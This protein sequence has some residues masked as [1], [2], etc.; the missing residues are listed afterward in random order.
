MSDTLQD[1]V[2]TAK[3]HHREGRLHLAEKFYREALAAAPAH[4]EALHGLGMLCLETRR[5]EEAV[6]HLRLAAAEDGSAAI[7]NNLGVALTRLQRFAEAAEVFRQAVAAE[8]DSVQSLGNLG[9]VLVLQ[10]RNDEALAILEKAAALA[11]DRAEVNAPLGS[12][13]LA[14]HR[15]AEAVPYLEKAVAHEPRRHEI[16]ADLGSAL[17][18]CG[19]F[20]EAAAAFNAVLALNPASVQALCGLGE[21]L[22][23]LDRHEDAA[24]HFARALALAPGIALLHYNYG[25]ALAF[26]GR[27]EEAR[28]AFAR[29]AALDP[30]VPSY[31]YAA[32][33]TKKTAPDD[34]HL[35]A[36][37][38]MVVHAERY[39]A[40]EQAELHMALA[41]AYDDLEAYS[42]AFEHLKQGNAIK[43]SLVAYDEEKELA[44][45]KAV[46]AVFGKEFLAARAGQG[47]PS[48]LP[49]FIVGMPRSG[50][51]LVEQILASHPA[52]YGAGERT[53]LPDLVGAGE[54]GADFP[55]NVA[56]LTLEALRHLGERIVAKL[57]ALAPKATHVTDK[58][59]GNFLYIGLI[60]LMLPRA[61]I[62]HVRRNALDTC[63]SCFTKLFDGNV[64]YTY[65]LGELGR[66]YRAY[67]ALM[68]HWRAVL[69]EGAMV[70]IDY[71][72]LVADFEPQT[73]RLLAACG[74][75]WDA[76]CLDFHKTR[77]NVRTASTFQV[78]Q[79]LYQSAVGRAAGYEAW[80]APLRAALEDAS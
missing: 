46:A 76:R 57:S 34:P 51:S 30:A 38:A 17:I 52:V 26:L 43:R 59:P 24:A 78:R 73:R 13:L 68:A 63:F 37:E 45:M 33:A 60:R 64:P 19:R 12:T 27:S 6:K 44:A 9:S 80:L 74:L 62:V 47:D 36:L 28:R 67:A 42:R 70:E 79:P 1:L 50:T 55:S 2:E 65:D 66:Y 16:R 4:A 20:R 39:P 23:G 25:S 11:P 61:R 32:M 71:E 58:L 15:P 54:A 77:R 48:P 49:I 40:A 8:P 41:K 56:G 14:L 7:C 31:R 29:A 22:G 5:G 3:T 75:D 21:A 69:P 18:R 72:A 53:D 35:Q 10:G